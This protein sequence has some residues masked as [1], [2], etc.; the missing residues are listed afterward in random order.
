MKRDINLS[1]KLHPEAQQAARLLLT[2]ARPAARGMSR[3]DRAV[4]K[5][6]RPMGKK[7]G[8]GV[9]ELKMRW[10]DIAGPRL[11][12]VCTPDKLS[13]NKNGQTLTVRARGSAALLVQAQSSQL[14]ERINLLAGSGRVTGLRIVQGPVSAPLPKTGTFV[15]KA[16]CTPSEL[17]ALDEQ[18]KNIASDELRNALRELGMGVMSR[19]DDG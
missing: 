13:G 17:T 12:A 11:A 2:P 3:P 8:P 6:L 19:T 16:G 4:R 15:Q 1:G 5:I 9:R 14:L 18:L 10:Q 7:F